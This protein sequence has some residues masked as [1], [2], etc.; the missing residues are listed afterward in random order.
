MNRTSP[1]CTEF[2]PGGSPD[3]TMRPEGSVTDTWQI[4]QKLNSR[5]KE[6]LIQSRWAFSTCT[7]TSTRWLFCTK[8]CVR[9]EDWLCHATEPNEWNWY[10]IGYCTKSNAKPRETMIRQTLNA[11]QWHVTYWCSYSTLWAGHLR[12]ALIKAP[13]KGCRIEHTQVESWYV[14]YFRYQSLNSRTYTTQVLIPKQLTRC[15]S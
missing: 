10:T 15:H 1:I 9:L 13:F 12:Y 4:K 3:K 14:C 11:W 8:G 2:H 6:A 5:L 7:S